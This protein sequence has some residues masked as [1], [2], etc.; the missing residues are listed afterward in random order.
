MCCSEEELAKVAVAAAHRK[1]NADRLDQLEA[2]VAVLE[3]LLDEM[4]KP[5]ASSCFAN[6]T[7]SVTP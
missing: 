6:F 7:V 2:R 1:A 5:P 4:F 3:K